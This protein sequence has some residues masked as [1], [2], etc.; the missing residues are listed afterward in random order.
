ML[1]R[2]TRGLISRDRAERFDA[3]AAYLCIRFR[4]RRPARNSVMTGSGHSA[5]RSQCKVQ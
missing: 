5:T 4:A 1:D 3:E 2:A